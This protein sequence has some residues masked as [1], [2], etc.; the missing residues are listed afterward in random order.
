MRTDS[1][2]QVPASSVWGT[3]VSPRERVRTMR[4]QRHLAVAGLACAAG[5]VIGPTV[6]SLSGLLILAAFIGFVLGSLARA[7]DARL[8]NW[9]GWLYGEPEY[10][11]RLDRLVDGTLR[12]LT[13]VQIGHSW[14]TSSAID[15]VDSEPRIRILPLEL[16]RH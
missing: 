7:A 14:V 9:W 15:A 6:Y 13:A 5:V 10:S 4:M 16:E 8:G 12:R 11:T 3:L 2:R 1:T